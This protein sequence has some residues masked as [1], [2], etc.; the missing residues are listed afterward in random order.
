MVQELTQEIMLISNLN[1]YTICEN[2][3]SQIAI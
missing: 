3:Q 1:N 2:T